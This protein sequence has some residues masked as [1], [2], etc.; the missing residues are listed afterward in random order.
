MSSDDQHSNEDRPRPR[1]GEVAPEGWSWHPPGGDSA[2]TAATP[3]PP[4][5]SPGAPW[6]APAAGPAGYAR[7]QRPATPA[8]DYVITIILIVLGLLGTLFGVAL[9]A[10]TPQN[11]QVLYTQEGLG[12]YTPAAAVGGI[13]AGGAIVEVAVWLASTV[14]SIVLLAK[15]RRAFYVPLIGMIV[16]FVVIFVVISVLLTTDPTL[17]NYFSRP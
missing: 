15:R 12:R 9:L 2:D 16:S 4:T 5:G 6:T 14:V 13:I 10:T 7:P 11:L 1:Y 17:I 8:W 3:P